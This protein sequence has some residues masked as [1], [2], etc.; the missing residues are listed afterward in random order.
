MVSEENVTEEPNVIIFF[1]TYTPAL[2]KAQ[3]K[4]YEPN[5]PE[6]LDRNVNYCRGKKDTEEYKKH[7]AILMTRNKC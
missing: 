5:K 2:K 4:Y 1:K 7:K 6:T 3:E